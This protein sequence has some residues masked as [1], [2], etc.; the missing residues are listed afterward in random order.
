MHEM[1]PD[2]VN[3]RRRNSL[4]RRQ[5][6]NL[7]P[8]FMIHVDGYDKLEIYGLAIHG[9]ICGYVCIQRTDCSDFTYT[10]NL[11]KKVKQMTCRVFFLMRPKLCNLY[12][13]G[14]NYPKGI[15]AIS[16]W[17]LKFRTQFQHFQ[18]L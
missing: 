12:H 3:M 17:D 4:T 16:T 2:G 1:D 13:G 9:A 18:S 15:I 6:H 7:G 11:D 10:A 5:Y 14:C 8:N